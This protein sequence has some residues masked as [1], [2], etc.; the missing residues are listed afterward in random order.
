MCT[1]AKQALVNNW[2][3]K[4]VNSYTGTGL[5]NAWITLDAMRFEILYRSSP[6]L[7]QN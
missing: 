4:P 5:Q 1:T 7:A 6:P 2:D 3:A